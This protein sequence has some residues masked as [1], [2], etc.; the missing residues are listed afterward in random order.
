[1]TSTNRLRTCGLA[2][3]MVAARPLDNPAVVPEARPVAWLRQHETFVEA[4]RAGDVGLLF[5]GDSITDL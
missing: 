3:L 4:A 2:L 5:L 1:M